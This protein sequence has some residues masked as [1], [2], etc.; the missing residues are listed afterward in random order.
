MIVIRVS[1]VHNISKTSHIFVLNSTS[2]NNL[3]VDFAKKLFSRI[4]LCVSSVCRKR[5]EKNLMKYFATI[6]ILRTEKIMRFWRWRS[7]VGVLNNAFPPNQDLNISFPQMKLWNF[8]IFS[9]TRTL[10][11]LD[12]LRNHQ[13]EYFSTLWKTCFHKISEI[14]GKTRKLKLWHR[15]KQIES[16]IRKKRFQS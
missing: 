11:C 1:Q 10:W 6:N 9:S 4:C 12:D 5:S 14:T 2:S 13:G 8:V 3:V 16:E 15:K 7:T